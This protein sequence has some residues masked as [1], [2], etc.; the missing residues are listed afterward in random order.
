MVFIGDMKNWD[1]F[2]EKYNLLKNRF[3]EQENFDVDTEKEL[4]S[5]KEYRERLLTNK[6]IVDSVSMINRIVNDPSVKLLAEGANATM[7]DIDFGTYPYVTSSNTGVAG[8]CTGLGVPPNKIETRIGVVKAYTTRVGE[9]P[10]PTE[11]NSIDTTHDKII[12]IKF[13]F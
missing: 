9:G 4:K 8:I 5:L 2:V 13:Y 1:S 11:L 7:L 3:K 6:M 10:F 12:I